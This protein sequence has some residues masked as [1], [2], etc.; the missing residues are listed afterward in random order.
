MSSQ[1]LKTSSS[2]KTAETNEDVKID[3]KVDTS[4]QI[5]TTDASASSKKELSQPQK[6]FD[7]VESEPKSSEGYF[8]EK[9][10]HGYLMATFTSSLK[11]HSIKVE[12]DISQKEIM[13]NTMN[14]QQHSP[15]ELTLMLKKLVYEMKKLNILFVV[16]QVTKS[17][18]ISILR[19]QRFFSFVNENKQH[20]FITVKCPIDRFPEAVIHGLGF[21]DVN[22]RRTKMQNHYQPDDQNED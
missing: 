1:N 4:K 22:S 15:V 11:S 6:S 5:A 3:S 9:S 17:D 14:I 20:G 21:S 2:V 7:K 12:I 18:W 8:I 10:E 16:Q 13:I 19:P